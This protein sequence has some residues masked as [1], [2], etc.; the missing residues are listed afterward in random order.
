MSEEKEMFACPYE[1]CDKEFDS[2][3]GLKIH[4]SMAHKDEEE[5][6]DDTE[7]QEE[8]DDKP[9]K[10]KVFCLE[11]HECEINK[12]PMVLKE[13]TTKMLTPYEYRILGKDER[14]LVM[15]VNE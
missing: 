4:I 8:K 14:G 15:K 6:V 11:N 7:K 9:D 3:K 2:E 13:K 10:I 1:G 12:K 5:P